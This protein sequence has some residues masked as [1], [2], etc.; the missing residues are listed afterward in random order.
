MKIC[1]VVDNKFRDLHGLYDLKK[2]LK[3]ENSD[4]YIINKFHWLYA[5]KLFNPHYVVLPNLHEFMGMPILRFCNKNSI[6]VILYNSE[7]FHHDENLFKYYFPKKEFKNLYKIYVWSPK[8][9]RQLINLGYPNSKILLVGALKLQ[10]KKIKKEIKRI[11]KIGIVS[12]GKYFST[13]FGAKN[14][15]MR[16]LFK[17]KNVSNDSVNTGVKLMHYEIEFLSIIRKIIFL[18]DKK[19][20]FILRPHPMEDSKFYENPYFKIDNSKNI[21]D[22]LN[23]VD[24]IINHYSSAS[25]D[26]LVH[27]VPAISI[28][29]IVEKSYRFS[30]LN[31][32]FPKNLAYKPKN[33]NELILILKDKLFLK[34]YY[35]NYKKKINKLYY[36]HHTVIDGINRVAKSF[37]CYPK[38][39]KFNFFKSLIMFVIYEIYFF[40]K[41]N[42]ETAYRPYSKKDRQLLKNYSINKK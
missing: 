5:I 10:N 3:K 28:E 20:E 2:K 29:N 31:N 26:A 23:K 41:Y 22:F 32:F 8:E 36:K 7:G 42:I 13:R 30:V 37:D 35:H 9:K 11:K 16:Q 40:M 38:K 4:L 15:I 6:R 1:W 14:V 25:L 33:L 24:V 27:N 17:R 12:T 18:T 39:E 19:Y 34:N 21:T